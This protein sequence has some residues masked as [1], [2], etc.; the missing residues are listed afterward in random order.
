[1]TEERL[2]VVITNHPL[3]PVIDAELYRPIAKP[4]TGGEWHVEGEFETRRVVLDLDK[5]DIQFRQ[6]Q[7]ISVM[8]SELE[9]Q[10][11]FDELV[12]LVEYLT[13]LR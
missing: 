3:Q 8:P 2:R 9:R 6:Q 5:K 4:C 10:L 13:T 12:D 11:T 7:K 1:M